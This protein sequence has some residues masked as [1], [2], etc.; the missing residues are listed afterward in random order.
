MSATPQTDELADAC[1]EK[2]S[3]RGYIEM[4]RLARTLERELMAT[5]AINAELLS[6]LETAR[7][8]LA[9]TNET[10]INRIAEGELVYTWQKDVE[11]ALNTTRA[12]LA[13]AK[14]GQS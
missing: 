10:L 7:E 4:E 14:G 11:Q 5:K 3:E 9:A 12:T 2:S 6:A 8:E 1:Y 13:K